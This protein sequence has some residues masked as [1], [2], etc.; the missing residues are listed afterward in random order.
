MLRS[1]RSTGRSPEADAELRSGSE[2]SVRASLHIGE[3]KDFPT[4]PGDR[5]YVYGATIPRSGAGRAPYADPVFSHWTIPKGDAPMHRIESALV[6]YVIEQTPRGERSYDIYSRLL[7][8]RI[9]FLGEEINSVTANLVIAQLLHLERDR[10]AETRDGA[11]TSRSIS[12]LRRRRSLRFVGLAILDTIP[13]E[14]HQRPS[15]VRSPPSAW[16]WRT[17]LHG[18]RARWPAAAFATQASASS[19]HHRLPN[20]MVMIHQP[21]GGRQPHSGQQRTCGA[22]AMR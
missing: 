15:P 6:P 9:I 22:D 4:I 14:L 5:M 16:A 1:P 3:R 11:A 2:H 12:T 10:D 8:D 18:S 13:P 7:N 17:R 19:P 20:S 21:S